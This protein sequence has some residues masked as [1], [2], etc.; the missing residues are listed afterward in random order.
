MCVRVRARENDRT[1]G[2]NMCEKIFEDLR[3]A[4]VITVSLDYI[5]VKVRVYAYCAPDYCVFHVY[6]CRARVC[7]CV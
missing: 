4:F 7:V 1:R 5:I 6:V 3:V 2:I